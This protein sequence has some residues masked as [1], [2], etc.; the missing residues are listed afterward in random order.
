MKA[1]NSVRQ[2]NLQLNLSIYKLYYYRAKIFSGC[3]TFYKPARLL[4]VGKLS[5]L[6]QY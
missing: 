2:V 4:K 1:C 6:P 5:N 3:F